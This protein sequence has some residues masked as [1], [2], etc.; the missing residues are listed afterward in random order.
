MMILMY[1]MNNKIKKNRL[2]F[3]LESNI[4]G[5]NPHVPG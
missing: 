4:F 2:K 1:Y 5:S 3:S